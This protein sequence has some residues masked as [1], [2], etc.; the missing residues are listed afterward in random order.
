MCDGQRAGGT[1]LTMARVQSAR[2]LAR[3]QKII[4]ERHGVLE[5]CAASANGRRGGTGIRD[6]LYRRR[7]VVYRPGGFRSGLRRQLGEFQRAQ[8]TPWSR[9]STAPGSSAGLSAVSMVSCKRSGAAGGVEIQA[10]SRTSWGSVNQGSSAQRMLL[11]AHAG[12][13][14]AH[15]RG[16]PEGSGCRLRPSGRHQAPAC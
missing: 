10:E 1:A 12:N 8:S 5:K 4:N 7:G 14:S 11:G 6:K 16:A 9:A 13:R 2:C 3:P 15:S